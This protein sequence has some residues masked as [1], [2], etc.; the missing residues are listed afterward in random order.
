MRQQRY[1]TVQLLPGRCFCCCGSPKGGP[2]TPQDA[3]LLL[4]AKQNAPEGTER[5]FNTPGRGN[6]CAQNAAG[7]CFACW[8]CHRR[9]LQRSQRLQLLLLA[10]H[11]SLLEVQNAAIGA[12][13]RSGMLQVNRNA[14]GETSCRCYNCCCRGH[15]SFMDATGGTT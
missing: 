1:H 4:L 10:R 14:L 2:A 11:R 5:S 3:A 7:R 8:R 12:T 6:P 9:L 13:E 15:R